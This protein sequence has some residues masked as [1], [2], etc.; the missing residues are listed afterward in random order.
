MLPRCHRPPWTTPQHVSLPLSRIHTQ[1][2]PGVLCRLA[3]NLA[4]SLI[5]LKRK[6]HCSIR[7]A[8]AVRVG[9]NVPLHDTPTPS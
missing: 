3:P 4:Q 2:V 7:Y 9:R 5:M 1:L 6:A 8:A